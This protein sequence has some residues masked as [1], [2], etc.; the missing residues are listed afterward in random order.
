MNEKQN[1][2]AVT[3]MTVNKAALAEVIYEK[4]NIDRQSGK[5]F[6]DRFFE[7]IV[8]H[9]KKGDVVKLPGLGNFSI[10]DKRARPGRNLKTGTAVEISERRVVN[11]HPSGTLNA[12]VTENLIKP[13]K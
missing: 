9:L 12:R 5:Q 3:G 10:R 1:E 8:E 2:E 4:H 13:E 7:L 6:V 11:F